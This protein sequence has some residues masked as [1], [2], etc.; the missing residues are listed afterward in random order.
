MIQNKDRDV[1]QALE[2]KDIKELR[3]KIGE[4]LW[5]SLMTRPD[6]AF[7]VNIIASEIPKD[8]VET[9]R[10]MNRLILKE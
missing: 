1:N 10:K 8:T 3:G 7:D 4:I 6:L 9:I 5:I 2:K